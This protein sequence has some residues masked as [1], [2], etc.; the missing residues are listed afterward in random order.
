M[1]VSERNISKSNLDTSQKEYIPAN[2]NLFQ[3]YKCNLT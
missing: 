2:L 1:Q 3:K